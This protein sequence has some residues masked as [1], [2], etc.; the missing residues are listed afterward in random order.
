MSISTRRGLGIVLLTLSAIA[1]IVAFVVTL[2]HGRFLGPSGDSTA[3]SYESYLSGY[4]FI[5]I[6]L[7]GIPGA[8]CLKRPSP[9]PPNLGQ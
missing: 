4:Y 8:V 6:A 3:F 9:K 2:S 5:P 1:A 7:F